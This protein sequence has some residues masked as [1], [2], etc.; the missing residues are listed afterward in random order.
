M[1]RPLRPA[2]AALV[3]AISTCSTSPAASQ[4]DPALTPPVA[5]S[6][7]EVAYPEGAQG[8]AAVVLELV[9]EKD[10]S[11][12]SAAVLEGI[13]PFAEPARS[14]ALTWRFT[15]AQRGGVPIRARITARVNFRQE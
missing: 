11:V 2:L 13:E 9:I 14:A 10:G 12:S 3:F 15:P 4:N 5:L 1:L 6:S 8:D 7:T